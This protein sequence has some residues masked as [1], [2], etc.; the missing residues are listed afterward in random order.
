VGAEGEDCSTCPL[1]CGVCC[2]DDSC[3][4]ALG[5]DCVTCHADCACGQGTLCDLQQRECVAACEPQCDQRECGPDG[6]GGTCGQGCDADEICS[7]A[8]QCEPPP[9]F[10]G[11]GLCDTANE[12]CWTCPADCGR[13]CGDG[14]CLAEHA[15]DCVSCDADCGCG[16]GNACDLQQRGCVPIC[17]PQC[18]QRECGPDRCG[19]TCAPG[20]DAGQICTEAGQCDA[21]PPLCGDG[22]C[23]AANEDCWTCPGDCG[24][25]CGDGECLAEHA[26]DC[27]TCDADC[28]CDQGTACDLQQ[29]GCVQ[30]CEPQCDGRECGP[31][32]C[33]GFCGPGCRIDEVCAADGRCVPPPPECGDDSCDGPGEDCWTCPAD[34]DACC[35][36]EACTPEHNETCASCPADCGC[37]DGEICEAELG[38]CVAGC[39][40]S[41][42]GR[43]CGSNGCDGSCGQCPPD[44][45]CVE[46]SG[47]CEPLCDRDCEGRV[48]GSDGCDGVCGECDPDQV[49]SADGACLGG[50]LGCDCGPDELCLDGVCRGLGSVCSPEQPLGLCPS[51]Q[52]CVA[53][54]CT[55]SAAACSEGNPSGPCPLGQV[56]RGGECVDLDAA[57]LC[58]DGNPCTFDT[59]D[60]VRSRCVSAPAELACDDG[61]PC[62]TDTCV[63]GECVGVAI[64]GCVAP[65]TID[66]WTSPTNVGELVLAGDK[67]AGAAIEIGEAEAV[68][69]D[70][71]QR[72]SVAINL[73]PG[74]NV[75]SVRS[76]AGGQPSE[77]REVV[78]V[79][80]VTPPGITITPDGGVFPDG[81]TVT[82]AS[83]EPAELFLTTDGEVPDVTSPRY[84]A[85]R[86]LRVFD[87]TTLRVR[88]RDAAGNWSTEVV[89]ASFEIST[90]GTGWRAGQALPEP[91]VH[92]GVTGDG[93]W[94]YAV[95]GYDGEAARAEAWRLRPTD[96]A[97][98]VLPGLPRPR[99]QVAL[100]F[101]GGALYAFGGHEE[102][103]PLNALTRLVPGEAG[104]TVR[105]AMPS[106]RF[107]ATATTV[108]SHIYVMG[109]KTNAGVVLATHERYT[110]GNDTWTN[111]LLPL[112]R[113][114]YAGASV[115]HGGLIYLLGG[116]DEQGH[117]IATVDVYNPAANSWSTIPDMPLPRSFSA[118]GLQSN[119]GAVG[120]GPE[121]IVVAGGRLAD[122]TPSAAVHEYLIEAGVWR[123]RRSLPRPV[124]SLGAGTLITVGL[125]DT[126]EQQVWTVGGQPGPGGEAL[127]AEAQA[128][129]RNHD[130]LRHLAPLPEGRFLHGAVPL[131]GRI[132]VLGGRDFQETVAGWV[133]DPE[134]GQYASIEDLPS[135]QNGLAALE[136]AGR[137][138]AIG[139]DNA[140]GNAVPTV[141]SYDPAAGVWLEHQPMLTSRAR[142][143]A[144]V[145]D[146]AIYVIGGDNRGALGT[147]EIY[148]PVEDRWA[149]GPL[150]PE[151][152]EG[153]AAVAWRGHLYLAGGRNA[154]GQIRGTLLRLQ[155]D[156]WVQLE[157]DA[158]PVADAAVAVVNGQLNLLG[159][160]VG[161][162][163]SDRH[164]A[165]RLSGLGLNFEWLAAS[166]LMPAMDLHA[167][168]VVNGEIYLLGGNRSEDPGPNGVVLVQKL[169][170]RCFDGVQG[171]AEGWD[172]RDFPDTGDGCG[173]IDP[174]VAVTPGHAYA[175]HGNCGSW[176][177]CGSPQGCAQHVCT[178]FGH[179]VVI[180]YDSANDCR[181]IA[182]QQCDVF[183]NGGERIADTNWSGHCSLPA[184]YN[185]ECMAD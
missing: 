156:R 86:T 24:R 136:Y 26:E 111:N 1:D 106:T 5:E 100:A 117:P 147:V 149:V 173:A 38:R 141:R 77:A 130:Y 93:T 113:P 152:R 83:D 30:V 139:G 51:G 107:G 68:P 57:A 79:Y 121:G 185:V 151:A 181:R 17:E 33:A 109:G 138:W 80:D 40:P 8:G 25:C 172:G 91:R 132:Y 110:P 125:L 162:A 82:V 142:A 48:C 166:R 76:V 2:G 50:G 22:R 184:V 159:G 70:P 32:L 89:S 183:Q 4:A 119:V 161:G 75:Y 81:V 56:C 101:Q 144:A 14:E 6:C 127:S 146:E 11:D 158:L 64:D 148:D 153:A 105:R 12:D 126:A 124:H 63:A 163:L 47:Q 122:G 102:G 171:A 78:V 94:I 61:D 170:G 88:A 52:H 44:Q 16:Q 99:T 58:D 3:D 97:W 123:V 67:P 59:F 35:G 23:D 54:V 29:R 169:A 36:D 27:V 15:E 118:A 9:R 98:E 104:W 95:G 92:A 19:G 174:L 128:F 150:L 114:R 168:A 62:T 155:G 87:D 43:Q 60:F 10:C 13:C 7:Q 49:C 112:P 176:N 179:G 145:L 157:A 45:R 53:G 137:I 140:F 134:T 72:W 154:E 39:Q 103:E 90:E 18:D 71:E 115:E 41:C 165:Y 42:L 84:W 28:G 180:D 182:G 31:D 34:C 120:G 131:D 108:G 37:G 175:T 96:E 135:A 55:L 21:P 74:E 160:R 177:T 164:W 133:L 143:A 46:D 20:C 65:P 69:A 167:A 116:E 178:F 129:V 85:W 66:P 73:V